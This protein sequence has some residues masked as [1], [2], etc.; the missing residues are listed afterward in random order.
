MTSVLTVGDFGRFKSSS[1]PDLV[2]IL[3][4]VGVGLTVRLSLWVIDI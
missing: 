1:G 3:K 4:K 2:P